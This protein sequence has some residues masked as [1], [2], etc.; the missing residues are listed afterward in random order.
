MI[1][2]NNF[3]IRVVGEHLSEGKISGKLYFQSLEILGK[4]N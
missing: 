4:N 1:L 2:L 3:Q